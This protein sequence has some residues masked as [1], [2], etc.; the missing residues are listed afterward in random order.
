MKNKFIDS[1]TN[2]LKVV[3][4]TMQERGSQYADTWGK[5]GCWNLTKAVTEKYLTTKP[6]TEICEI[7]A[8]ACFIDQKYSRYSG[9]Y[10]QDTTVDLVSYLA[11]LADMVHKQ[12]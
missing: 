4:E 8:L 10:K 11:A 2:T 9:G 5:D 3:V 7:I 1:A 12:Q 6:T